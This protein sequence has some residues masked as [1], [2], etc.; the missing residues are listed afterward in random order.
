MSATATKQTP[1]KRQPA[2]PSLA[3]FLAEDADPA[4]IFEQLEHE[5]DGLDE[6]YR[7]TFDELVEGFLKR[8]GAEAIHFHKL[9]VHVDAFAGVNDAIRRAGFVMGFEYCRRLLTGTR[10]GGTR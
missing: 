4:A 9:L 3:A 6:S 5:H 1:A 8:E 2:S 10:A 7:R